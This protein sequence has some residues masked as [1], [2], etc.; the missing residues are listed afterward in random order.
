MSIHL[1]YAFV[2]T[3]MYMSDK[4]HIFSHIASNFLNVRIT[5]KKNHVSCRTILKLISLFFLKNNKSA[6]RCW[7]PFVCHVWKIR[8][9]EV[10]I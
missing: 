10:A 9:L 1:T 7:P 6:D 2:E 3:E 5:F 8:S 4:V